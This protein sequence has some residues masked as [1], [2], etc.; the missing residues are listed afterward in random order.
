MH[1]S[2]S[3]A[4]HVSSIA[5]FLPQIPLSGKDSIVGRAFVVHADTDDLGKGELCPHSPLPLSGPWPLYD[6]NTL[7]LYLPS[8]VANTLHT[9]KKTEALCVQTLFCG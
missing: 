5:L 8:F 3:H 1:V 7:V 6:T 9:R 2:L 4:S